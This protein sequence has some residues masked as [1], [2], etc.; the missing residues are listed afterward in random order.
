[1][2]RIGR[3]YVEIYH[4]IP[5]ELLGLGVKGLIPGTHRNLF[6]SEQVQHLHLQ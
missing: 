6:G 5:N 2:R 1:M 3:E 4:D